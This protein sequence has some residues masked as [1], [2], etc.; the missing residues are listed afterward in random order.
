MT[1]AQRTSAKAARFTES[2]I[3]EMSRVCAREGG[4]N[5]AQ[6]FPDF[7][8]PAPM[9]DAACRAIQA[10]FNQ[11][12][13]T[14]GAPRLRQAIAART[15][16]YNGLPT[17]AERD[18]TVC[19][20][21]TEAMIAALLAV[22]DPGD[23]VVIFEPF[24]ENYGPDCILSGATPRMVRLAAPDWSLDETAL[25]AALGP[26]T[27][28]IVVNTPHNPTGKVF[29]R[30]E[31]ECIARLCVE[32]DLLAITDEIYEY[33][34]YDGTEHISLATLPG[35][36]ERTITISGLSKTWSA[37]GWRIGWCIAP[38][39]I[40]SAIRKVHDFLTVGAPAPLQEAAA[41]ALAFGP[42]YFVNLARDYRERRD[43]LAAVLRETG[44]G[45]HLPKGAYYIMTDLVGLTTK[46]DVSF[47]MEL[48]AKG[49]V[50]CVPGSSFFLDPADGRR[51]VR[52]CFAKK[53]ETLE[54][55]ALVLRERLG[56]R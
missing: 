18:I 24:Y 48:V 14:W 25:R 51:S 36:R 13:V 46:D 44:F 3:R 28:A 19:C 29:T 54:R 16:A 31:L 30:E 17:D 11:Y 20:G 5:L 10:D 45:V 6:G 26:R 37:T 1:G 40:T 12:A 22:L 32:R 42:E 56:R 9:K 23:E 8:A 47:A 21:A 34:L 53:R 27:R 49:G 38:P 55:A 2:V 33:I 43:L 41:D 35:M 7:A 50:A 4:V 39:E 15:S 52:F